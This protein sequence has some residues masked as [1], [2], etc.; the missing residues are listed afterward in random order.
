MR[1]MY[2][3]MYTW[4]RDWICDQKSTTPVLS[5]LTTFV[6]HVDHFKSLY[7]FQNPHH[8]QQDDTFILHQALGTTLQ[9][10]QALATNSPSML[11]LLLSAAVDT[12]TQL[13]EGP[14]AKQ[15]ATA[16]TDMARHAVLTMVNDHGNSVNGQ[17]PTTAAAG[18]QDGEQHDG[19]PLVNTTTGS[20]VQVVKDVLTVLQGHAGVCMQQLASGG[21]QA[22]Q[23]CTLHA[24]VC[25]MLELA[26]VLPQVCAMGWWV[27]E[28]TCGLYEY[29]SWL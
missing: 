19:Q 11:P 17:P 9:G 10:M 12:L 25:V 16:I 23:Q 24:V 21:E 18:G 3:G 22:T 27:M 13:P 8:H 1:W 7:T 6:I 5:M 14:A 2:G 29:C 26:A 28:C 15:T 4:I 20:L